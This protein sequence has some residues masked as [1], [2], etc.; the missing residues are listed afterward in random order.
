MKFTS[1]RPAIGT[2][3][4]ISMLVVAA[5]P[6]ASLALATPTGTASS[7]TQLSAPASAS[8]FGTGAEIK[9][10]PAG[11]GTQRWIPLVTGDRVAVDAKGTIVSVRPAA[12]REDIPIRVETRDGHTY[13]LPDDARDLVRSGRVDRRLFDITT[14][15]APAYADRHDLRLIVMY[16]AARAAAR[17]AVRA[18]GGARVERTL[19]SVNADAVAAPANGTAELWSAVTNGS[20]DAMKRSVAPGIASV[21]LDSVVQASLDKSVPQIGGPE[22]WA[23]GFDGTGTRVAVLDTGVDTTHP[24]LA[25]Q[26]VAEQNFSDSPDAVDR[27]GHGTHVASITAGTGAKSGGTYKGVAPGARL[28]NGKVLGDSGSGSMSQIIAGMEWAVAEKADVVNLS[29]GT[30]DSPEIDPAE[31]A[32]NR[33]SAESGALFVIAAGNNGEQGAGTVG[34]PGSADAALTVGAVDKQDRLASFSSTGPRVGDGGIK[35]DLTAPGVAIGAAAAHDSYLST[36]APAVADGYI[37]LNGTSMATPHV[38]GAAAILVQQHPD[39]SGDDIKDAL[40][41]STTS[42]GYTPFEQGSGRV[43][44][45]KAIKQ[46]VVAGQTSLSFGVAQWPHTDDQPLTRDLTYRNSG[47]SPVTLK[48]AVDATGPDGSAAPDGMF[49]ADEQVTVP[50]HGEASVKVTA[51]TRLGGDTTGAFTGRITATGDGQTVGTALAVDRESEMYTVTVNTLDRKGKPAPAPAWDAQLQGLSGLSKGTNLVLSG[52]LHSVRVPK[53]RYFLNSMVR[54]DPEGSYNQGGDWFNQPDL[55]VTKDTVVTVDART[56]KPLDITVPDRSARPALG[57]FSAG[58]ELADGYSTRYG[59][60]TS[61]LAQYR[62]AHLGPKAADG[63]RL[64]QQLMTTYSTGV[65]GHDEYHLV[66]QP[67]GDRYLTGF[68]HHTK[69]REFA[70]VQVKLGAPAKGKFGFITPGTEGGAGL[71]TVHALPY[72]GTLHLL[73]GNPSWQLGFMQVDANDAYETSYDALPRT[74]KPGRSYEHVFNVGVFGPDLPEGAGLV[75]LIRADEAIDGRLPLF[76]D[77][78]GNIS[79]NNSPIESART[80]LYRNGEL[81]NSSIYPMDVF[82]IAEN[83]RA[84]YRLTVSVKRGT[85]ADVSTNMTASW[86]FSSEYAPGITKLP[87]SVVRFTPALSLDNTGKAGAKV[88]VPV[89]V[90]GT[91]AGRN[92]KSLSVWASYDK[93]ATWHKLSVCDGRVQVSNPKAGGSV[94]FK[95]QAVDK[96]GNTVDETIIDAYL[97]K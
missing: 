35:P 87:T 31:A 27:F 95:A 1:K 38:A 69:A 93:G 28:L 45:R 26:V 56:A 20:G 30:Y 49:T 83:E 18:A 55:D 90:H 78:Q 15:S 88:W 13:A 79:E 29:L 94:S 9:G 48:L 58:I 77:S 21:W 91:A 70:K 62:T 42:G 17:S 68:T 97:T 7:T 40:V 46:T 84:D 41:S 52:D 73:S 50:A 89:T 10:V 12:G 92:L 59:V 85:V 34:S 60:F 4:G 63:D 86:T 8:T 11:S 25:G 44:L 64:T 5:T 67:T 16:D 14:L 65:G 81:V 47:D 51:D 66:Y 24:D 54:V 37:A 57:F 75:G 22:A 96:Q 23:A 80:S 61:S 33:L 53:G 19:P 39:W 6:S 43:D 74:F 3:L 2:V 76:S 82:Y 71:G 36:V 72:T 32:V